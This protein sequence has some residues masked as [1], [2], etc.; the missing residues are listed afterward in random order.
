MLITEEPRIDPMKT[1][2]FTSDS[3]VSPVKLAVKDSDLRKRT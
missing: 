1:T 2:V 3:S